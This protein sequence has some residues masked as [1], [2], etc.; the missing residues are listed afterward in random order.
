MHTY[1]GAVYCESIQPI[2]SSHL[3][4]D[5]VGDFTGSS[6]SALSFT[7]SLSAQKDQT[8]FSPE[9]IPDGFCLSDCYG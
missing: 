5:I 2:F 6:T 3:L 4:R 1:A 8:I 9:C 7:V